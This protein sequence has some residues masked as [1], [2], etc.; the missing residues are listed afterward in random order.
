METVNT[1]A[2][3]A[4]RGNGLR[5]SSI[6]GQQLAVVALPAAQPYDGM[7]QA[8]NIIP[9]GDS[10]EAL[11]VLH[12]RLSKVWSADTSSDSNWSVDNPALGQ[13]AVT[14]LIVQDEFGGSLLRSTVNGASHYWNR[15]PDGTEADL[16]RKQ[17][18][19]PLEFGDVVERERDYVLSFP[20]TAERYRLLADL[21]D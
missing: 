1:S 17:F 11:I 19:E 8:Y 15:L 6:I 9:R 16:T 10:Q 2:R 3:R 18:A 21:L 12:H 7:M 5:P 14:A 4:L 13:C 20:A